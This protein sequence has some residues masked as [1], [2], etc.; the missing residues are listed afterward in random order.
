[1]GAARLLRAQDDVGLAHTG[2]GLA[3]E[4][5]DRLGAVAGRG[6]GLVSKCH[7]PIR[8]V[9]GSVPRKPHI[10]KPQYDGTSLLSFRPQNMQFAFAE[11]ALPSSPACMRVTARNN[12][13][14]MPRLWRAGQVVIGRVPRSGG[15][16]ATGFDHSHGDRA[17]PHLHDA[18]HTLSPARRHSAWPRGSGC[19]CASPSGPSRRCV[20]NGWLS[21]CMKTNHGCARLPA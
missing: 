15:C 9:S 21:V 6:V 8:I 2:I 12:S 18:A 10:A 19:C 1:L 14:R 17:G 11:V 4:W 5:I 13:V 20:I 7:A 3:G 16:G